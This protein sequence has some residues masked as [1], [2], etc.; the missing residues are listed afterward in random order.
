MGAVTQRP[1]HC[2]PSPGT[3]NLLAILM[4]NHWQAQLSAVLQW[5]QSH[6][7]KKDNN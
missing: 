5:R 2:F 3:S 1:L 4:F 7:K 6:F